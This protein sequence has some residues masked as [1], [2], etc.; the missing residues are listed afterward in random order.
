MLVP[1]ST[2]SVQVACV[3]DMLVATTGGVFRDPDSGEDLGTG[4]ERILQEGL[5]FDCGAEIT[6]V[7]RMVDDE[8]TVVVT[9]N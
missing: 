4:P 5:V 8:F 3:A 1:N 6:F 7:Y 2:D 9:L